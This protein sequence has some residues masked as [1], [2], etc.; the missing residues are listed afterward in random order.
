MWGGEVVYD[1][2]TDTFLIVY[3]HAGNAVSG[4]VCTVGTSSNGFDVS[5]EQFIA[6]TAVFNPNKLSGIFSTVSNRG[7]FVAGDSN[8]SVQ[9]EYFF[10][11]NAYTSTNLN[12][13]NF[14]GI[15][16]GAYA[17]AAT[18]TIQIVGSVDDAQSGLTA[19]KRYYV[20]TDGSLSRTADSP[21]VIAGTAVS[22]TEIIVKG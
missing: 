15:S 2:N 9:G 3:E 19:G 16:D 6:N 5:S 22:A 11:N 17:D 13:E 14:I 12:D 10:F 7:L 21:S 20:Q 4:R 8:A 18:A 1:S